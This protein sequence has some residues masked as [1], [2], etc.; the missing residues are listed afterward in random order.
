M[1]EYI[2]RRDL[3][4]EPLAARTAPGSSIAAISEVGI[5]ASKVPT[6]GEKLVAPFGLKPFGRRQGSARD[7]PTQRDDSTR[8]AQ[9][10][11]AVPLTPRFRAASLYPSDVPS[12]LNERRSLVR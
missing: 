4:D 10:R 1:L 8:G 9:R 7:Q 12:Y 6:L 11:P 5:A 3:P 2:V